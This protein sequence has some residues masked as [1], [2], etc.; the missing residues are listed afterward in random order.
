MP[1][2]GLEYVRSEYG[3]NIRLSPTL[4]IR[5]CLKII[6]SMGRDLAYLSFIIVGVEV[7][8]ALLCHNVDTGLSGVLLGLMVHAATKSVN[9]LGLQVDLHADQIGVPGRIIQI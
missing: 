5:R 3:T 1:T 2:V 9:L 7:E 6:P 8:I 4:A